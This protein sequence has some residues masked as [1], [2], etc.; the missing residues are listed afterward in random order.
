M[1]GLSGKRVR[2]VKGQFRGEFG[3]IVKE[4][5]YTEGYGV[6]CEIKL[7]NGHIGEWSADFF[8]IVH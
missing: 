3:T 1:F 4:T 5:G 8:E 7:D 6:V 2:I